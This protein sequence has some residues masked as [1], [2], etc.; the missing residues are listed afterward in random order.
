MT[1]KKKNRYSTL[2]SVI[3][4]LILGSCRKASKCQTDKEITS[5]IDINTQNEIGNK[6]NFTENN[7]LSNINENIFF[8]ENKNISKVR[9][10]LSNYDKYISYCSKREND[11]DLD[12]K[13]FQTVS[14]AF[15]KKCSV[16]QSFRNFEPIKKDEDLNFIVKKE[17]IPTAVMTIK[18]QIKDLHRSKNNNSTLCGGKTLKRINNESDKSSQ[19]SD[20]SINQR[21]K[22]SSINKEISSNFRKSNL[23]D[24]DGKSAK[25]KINNDNKIKPKNL[26]LINDDSINKIKKDIINLVQINGNARNIKTN[27]NIVDNS[28]NGSFCGIKLN[29]SIEITGDKNKSKQKINNN[30]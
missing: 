26:K 28:Y 1:K 25:I 6:I 14:A 3:L 4:F 8:V 7:K 18:P 24:L 15:T 16:Q 13:A 12:S 17:N 2:Y 19:I 23:I 21:N 22:A 29:Y 27:S 11:N 9:L 10:N 30:E 5:I 20:Y